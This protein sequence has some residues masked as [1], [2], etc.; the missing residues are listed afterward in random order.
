M[1][2]IVAR[3]DK[4]PL[5]V[6]ATSPYG[7]IASFW[8]CADHFWSTPISRQLQSG[9][10]LRYVPTPYFLGATVVPSGRDASRVV[11]AYIP[12]TEPWAGQPR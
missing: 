4:P 3:Q 10:A 5:G 11:A 2:A 8:P 1:G 7:S 12:P 9:S 6:R